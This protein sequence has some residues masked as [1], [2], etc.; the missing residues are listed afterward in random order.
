MKKGREGT[1]RSKMEMSVSQSISS[2]TLLDG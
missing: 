1:E 2:V